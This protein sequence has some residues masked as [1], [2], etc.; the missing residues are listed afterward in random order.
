M[1]KNPYAGKF[2][3][4]EGLD[5]SGQ[6]TQANLLKDF[7]LEKNFNVILTKEPTQDSEA[8]KKI[9]KILD[10]KA[11]VQP[12]QLQKLFA[13]DRKEHL[14]NI[15]IPALKEGKIVISDRYFFSSFAYGS[16]SGVNLEWL[17]KINDEFLLP[18]LTFILKVS[19][20]IC[21]GRIK[22]RGD[23]ITLFE[24][25]KKSGK[26]IKSCQSCLKMFTP[27]ENLRKN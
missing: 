27:L 26:F 22:K 13:Q 25:K 9:R 14:E 17:I 10:K 8:G 15:I 16:A 21:L 2:I 23:K 19:P 18:N 7:L 5:G 20:K 1:Q 3:V 24:E 12:L 11:G 6:S 4:F